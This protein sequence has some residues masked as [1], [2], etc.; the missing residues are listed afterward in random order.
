MIKKNRINFINPVISS[1]KTLAYLKKILK[2][3]LPNEGLVTRSF[4]NKI[5]KLLNVKYVIATTSGTVAIF[6]AL[7]AL[8]IK[9][10]DE[11]LIP[12]ITF[13]ATVNAV[14][15]V[16]A[17]PVLVDINKE[18]LLL[19]L[20]NLKK[21]IT[22]KTKAIIPVHISGRGSNIGELIKISKKFNLKI[23]EDAAE[24]FLSKFKNKSLGTFGE[25]GCFSF[26]PPKMFTTGQGGV[27]IT[28]NF[29]YYKEVLKLKNQGRVGLTTG[30]E[31][32]HVSIGYNFKFTNLQSALG[33]AE[34]ENINW[35][36]KKLVEIHKLYKKN[37]IQNNKFKLFNFNLNE[38]ELPLWTDVY[39]HDRNKLYNFLLNKGIECRYFW[40]PLNYCKPYKKS[41]KGL[42]NSKKL[43]G[44]LMW[45]PSSLSLNKKDVLKI[46]KY[47]NQYYSTN[48]E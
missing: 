34:L 21:K 7:K 14:D 13:A 18:T 26:S 43:M 42:P 22:K 27:V 44:K 25:M 16:G 41:F 24:A 35:R 11:V 5:S 1:N 33:L 32:K 9:K 2:N 47:I 10:G 31:D 39:S 19:D 4:E 8:K 28:N 15:L 23:V 17:K 36:V 29:R 37:I 12:N 46:C 3:N 38:G 45:L 30:G 48:H 6:L 40:H 20:D